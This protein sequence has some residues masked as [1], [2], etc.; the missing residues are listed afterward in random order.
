MFA[1]GANSAVGGTIIK[2]GSRLKKLSIISACALALLT[3]ASPESQPYGAFTRPFACAR[4]W[5]LKPPRKDKG[6]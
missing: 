4:P 5:Y 2:R 1:V 3:S 6:W